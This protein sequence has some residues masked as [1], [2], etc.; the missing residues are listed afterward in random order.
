M[1]YPHLFQKLYPVLAEVLEADFKTA[2]KAFEKKGINK[3][4]IKRAFEDFKKLKPKIKEASDRDIDS[5][6]KKDW[7]EFLVFVEGLKEKKSK[8]EI[9]ERKN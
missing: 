6:A 9:K 5:W 3:E 1:Q 7:K 2:E 4:E 8:K